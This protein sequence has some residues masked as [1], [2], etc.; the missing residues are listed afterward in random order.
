[1]KDKIKYYKD[2]SYIKSKKYEINLIE[3]SDIVVWRNYIILDG[4]VRW[5]NYGYREG[6][7]YRRFW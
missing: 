4:K 5:E 7:G 3:N 2:E 1:M 6:N